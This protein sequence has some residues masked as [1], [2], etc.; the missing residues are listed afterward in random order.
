MATITKIEEQ[1][2]KKRVNI[3][4]DDAF[5]CG[6]NKETAVKFS[7]KVGKEITEEKLKEACFDSEVKSA[8]EKASNILGIR[9]HS[10]KEIFDKLFKKGYEKQVIE[11][12][13]LKLEEYGFVDD[14][15]F[16][17]EFV[18]SNSKYSKKI[19]EQKLKQKGVSPDIVFEILANESDFEEIEL[20]KKQAQ[21]YAKSKDVST[22]EGKQKLYASLVRKGFDF[23]TIKKACESLTKNDDFDEF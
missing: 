23:S 5:F 22:K 20:C 4:V 21:K 18:E 14:R 8:F 1:K 15:I 7:L 19:K 13:I 6:L 3:F 2:N 10:K 17:K 12:A 11:K 9:M 16:A